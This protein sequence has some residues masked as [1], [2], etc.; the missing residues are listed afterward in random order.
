MD[1]S[2]VIVNY[3]TCD[4][5]KNCIESIIKYTIDVS[6]EIIVV[7]NNSS[8]DSIEM[9][10]ST[11]PNVIVVA[12][13]ENIGFGAANNIG[14]KKASGDYIFYLNSDTY[15]LNNAIKIFY[16]YFNNHKNEN[17]GC[18]GCNLLNE[19]KLVG[20]SYFNHISFSSELLM[21]LKMNI[22]LFIATIS[23]FFFRK[24]K[25]FKILNLGKYYVGKVD[26]VLGADMFM[27]NNDNAFFDEYF[28][29][30]H[31]EADLQY[32]LLKKHNLISY[33]IEGPEIV[34]LGGGSSASNVDFIDFL[35]KK[36]TSYN[37][38]SK[39][40][41]FRKNLNNGVKIFILKVFIT[42]IWIN[43]YLIKEKKESIKTLWKV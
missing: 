28:F 19:N 34:H 10:R 16:Q 12:N 32:N 40:K 20:F 43:P 37:N 38:I 33:I 9:I 27:R 25:Q 15:F 8:D 35:N 17:L 30:Y 41:Y 22:K 36:T 7:D 26:A 2:I 29:M 6:Y 14:K 42:L 3:N 21:Y 39:I 13:S 18:L 24:K 23:R 5:L 31:E 4:L 1:V 11:F